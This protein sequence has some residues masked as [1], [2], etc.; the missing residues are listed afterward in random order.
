MS[1]LCGTYRNESAQCKNELRQCRLQK[2]RVEEQCNTAELESARWR[3]EALRSRCIIIGREQLL[4]E[5][6]IAF[7]SADDAVYAQKAR[8][9]ERQQPTPRPQLMQATTVRPKV[10]V[11]QEPKA[12]TNLADVA[13]QSTR[14]AATV[15]PGEV[16]TIPKLDPVSLQ[17]DHSLAAESCQ[18]VAAKLPSPPQPETPHN[19][20]NRRPANTPAMPASPARLYVGSPARLKLETIRVANLLAKSKSA[21]TDHTVPSVANRQLAASAFSSIRPQSFDE[22]NKTAGSTGAGASKTRVM[23]VQPAKTE[24]IGSGS[25][26]SV[27]GTTVKI[28]H[29]V[30]KS[31]KP[32]L[33]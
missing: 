27:G 31:K 15:V 26:G 2:A 13:D 6:G 7:A 1:Y 33:Y 11:K 29:V 21:S 14:I 20:E 17:T 3:F 30:V 28:R 9:R 8:E 10:E 32:T 24:P 12:Q 16:T 5:A 22:L 23:F 18:P 19:D 25:S 4:E